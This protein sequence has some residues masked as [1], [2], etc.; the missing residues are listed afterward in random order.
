MKLLDL[1]G[2]RF[3]R[4]T[5]LSKV[6]RP[7]IVQWLCKCDCGKVTKVFSQ[8]LR[9]GKTKSCGC[10][11]NQVRAAVHTKHGLTGTTYFHIWGTM[12]KRCYNP[13]TEQYPNYGGRGI[14]VCEFLR[15]SPMNL[16]MMIG[17]RPDSRHV[18]DRRDNNGHYSCGQCAEC[19][20]SGHSKNIRWVT[21]VQSARNRRNNRMLAHNG[22]TQCIAEWAE[23]C[24]APYPDFY[25]LVYR[26]MNPFD[27]FPLQH[28]GETTIT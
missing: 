23:A 19:L 20:K 11:C 4:L 9:D 24:A 28:H 1:T 14:R 26:G 6:D 3:G 16:I 13:N 27:K 12:I 21:H 8:C 18:I 17:E 2:Q 15:A 5:V 25:S 22:V 7:R 10:W